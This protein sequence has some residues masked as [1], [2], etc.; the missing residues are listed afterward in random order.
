MSNERQ[1]AIVTGASRGIGKATMKL[2]SDRNVLAI[3]ISRSADDSARDR[4][5][6]IR[7]ETSVERVFRE[8]ASTHGR[9]DA[10]VNCAGIAARANDLALGID[11]WEGM[12]RTNLIG[13]YFCCKHAIP[14]MRS[15]KYGRIVN[16]ASLAG[17]SYSRTA[18][19]A[20][21]ASKYG[22]VGLTRQLAAEYGRDGVNINCVAPSQTLS[23]MLTSNVPDSEL[24]QL[25]HANPMGRLAQPEEIAETICF[26]ASAQASYINGAIV[27]VNGGLV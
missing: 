13:T 26:L 24:K 16:V 10:L 5:C 15:Q 19:V 14:Q 11:D 8:I 25:A 20:Y 1:V 2:L 18:S 21:T 6:D 9:I 27:D 22:V 4:K 12:L 17:R 7:D 3:G 23:E